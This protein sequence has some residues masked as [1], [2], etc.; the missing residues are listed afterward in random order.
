MM[1]LESLLTVSGALL[2]PP[3][4][5][6]MIRAPY[7]LEAVRSG[8]L[9]KQLRKQTGKNARL[10]L[11]VKELTPQ[12]RYVSA[13]MHEEDFGAMLRRKIVEQYANNPTGCGGSFDELLC[14][15]IHSNGLTFRWLAE[16]WGVSLPTLGELIWDHC[17]QLEDL[18]S[19]DHEYRVLVPASDEFKEE[20]G[21]DTMFVTSWSPLAG[22]Q[23]P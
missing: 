11:R 20:H 19:V 21:E 9:N 15:E 6:Y 16:K 22:E 12:S 14:W 18:P 10:K 1:W 23:K 13:F 17:K 3:F 8:G 4:L 5:I 2:L 7:S